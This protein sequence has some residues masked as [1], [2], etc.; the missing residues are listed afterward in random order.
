[1][2]CYQWR[3]RSQCATDSLSPGFLD[4]GKIYQWRTRFRCATGKNLPVAH[5]KPGA[6]QVS[7]SKTWK[8]SRWRRE[9]TS[10]APA[11]SVPLVKNLPV[12]HHCLVH[13]CATG[14]LSPPTSK[15]FKFTYGAPLL[16]IY[17]WRTG[18]LCATGILS[19]SRNPAER[20]SVA[21]W[22]LV[23]HW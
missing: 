10:G 17:Q 18:I 14:T 13:R 12:A 19:K 1:M 4:L 7:S 16:K 6:P 3:T 22:D 9:S 23:R 20:L 2:R 5:R 21:H 15:I 11:S 8:N